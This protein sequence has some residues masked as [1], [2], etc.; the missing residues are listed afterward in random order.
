MRPRECY[1]DED[2]KD[3]SA[4]RKQMKIKKKNKC[5]TD[6]ISN[7][8]FGKAVGKLEESCC[9]VIFTVKAHLVK[10]A[11]FDVIVYKSF[12]NSLPLTVVFKVE[13]S[14]SKQQQ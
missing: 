4:S 14:W 5:N 6:N 9:Q 10:L 7:Y 12:F 1:V 11:G 2:E 13:I 3:S 8:F